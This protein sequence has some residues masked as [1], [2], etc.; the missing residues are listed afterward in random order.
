MFADL[1]WN[2][3]VPR[4]LTVEMAFQLFLHL[5]L[6]WD[7]LFSSVWSC[8]VWLALRNSG[9]SRRGRFGSWKSSEI[10]LFT[11]LSFP[12]RPPGTSTYWSIRQ[13]LYTTLKTFH[14]RPETSKAFFSEIE[15]LFLYHSVLIGFVYWF[16][17]FLK[18]YFLFT[19]RKS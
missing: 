10:D 19:N 16:F 4:L 5:K 3:C 9:N 1:N 18:N 15:K 17:L 14:V 13:M 7:A 8:Q 6:N 12:K 2:R 11:K